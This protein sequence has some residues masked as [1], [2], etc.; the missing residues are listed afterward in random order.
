MTTER[1]QEQLFYDSELEALRDDVVALGGPKAVGEWFWPEKS[2][3]ARRNMVN[4]RLNDERRERFTDEQKRLI[5]RK[6][7]EARGFSACLCFLCDD[8]G[9]ERP[10]ALNPVDEM[11]ALQRLYIERVGDMSRLADRMERLAT[12]P[13][14]RLA[15]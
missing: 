7:R 9:F 13:V 12:A 4:D 3:E 5:I 11:A 14:V 2:V 15:K 1:P 10:K 6:A 8:T